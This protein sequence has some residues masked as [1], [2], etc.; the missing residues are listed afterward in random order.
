MILKNLGLSSRKCL[1]LDNSI[2]KTLFVNNLFH[3]LKDKL[4]SLILFLAIFKRINRI[5]FLFAVNIGWIRLEYQFL[6]FSPTLHKR[7]VLVSPG[8]CKED[9]FIDKT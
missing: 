9:V 5:L 7:L 6:R 4:L 3:L 2:L 1:L 8:Y